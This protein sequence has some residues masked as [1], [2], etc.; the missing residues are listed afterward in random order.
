MNVNL[1]GKMEELRLLPLKHDDDEI[2]SFFF[3]ELE[4]LQLTES[5]KKFYILYLDLVDICQTL[6]LVLVNKRKICQILLEKIDD[7]YFQP[8]VG[9]LLVE[10]YRDCGNELYQE[11]LDIILP[12]LTEKLDIVKIQMV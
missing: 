10:L 7:I 12:T 2:G 5:S 11:T 6:P 4:T 9:K 1:T 3:D 8:I